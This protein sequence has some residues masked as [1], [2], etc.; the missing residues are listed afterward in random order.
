MRLSASI[1]LISVLFFHLSLHG[2]GTNSQSIRL[3]FDRSVSAKDSDKAMKAFQQFLVIDSNQIWQLTDGLEEFLSAEETAPSLLNALARAYQ[4]GIRQS[5]ESAHEYAQKK[6]FLAYRFPDHFKKNKSL[7]L[8]EAIEQ[9]PL[10]CAL[11]LYRFWVEQLEA[12]T[13]RNRMG[14]A[15]VAET[16]ARY[17]RY[18]YAR[19]LTYPLDAEASHQTRVMIHRKLAELIPDC[20]ATKKTLKTSSE[21]SQLYPALVLYSL[22]RCANEEDWARFERDLP[23]SAP[24]W[25]QRLL[26]Y[27]YQNRGQIEQSL[28]AMERAIAKEDIPILKADLH[29]QSASLYLKK[30]EFREARTQVM[31]AIR[32]TPTWGDLYLLLADIYL[33]GGKTCGFNDFDQK[34]VY[35]LAIDLS[36]R[37]INSSPH[38]QQEA[39]QRIFEYQLRMPEAKEVQFRGLSAGDTWPLKCWMNTVTTVKVN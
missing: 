8:S 13:M 34:A 29:A 21:T 38:L 33:E 6:A 16:W 3:E 28:S 27:H 1:F 15:K 9:S 4:I 18:L 12:G 10:Q 19:E 36:Q 30:Q 24:G 11:Q 31:A 23:N 22:H 5:P 17:D 32:L 2:Q 7:W 37:A 39:N 20:D 35:W 14:L 25:S 26:A